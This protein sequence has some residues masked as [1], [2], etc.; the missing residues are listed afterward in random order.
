MMN[1]ISLTRR[2]TQKN[3]PTL[4]QAAV[5][6]AIELLWISWKNKSFVNSRDTLI[7]LHACWCNALLS[8]ICFTKAITILERGVTH[9]SNKI[10]DVLAQ[11]S[12]KILD[13]LAQV[14]NRVVNCPELAET[15]QYHIPLEP[16][17]KELVIFG[18]SQLTQLVRDAAE[19]FNVDIVSI[20]RLYDQP[21]FIVSC[22]RDTPG[23]H[24]QTLTKEM[25]PHS[26]I[27]VQYHIEPV[28]KE[29]L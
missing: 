2:F 18:E 17:W 13:V 29:Y 20:I 26:F 10:W 27:Q 16:K 12:N 4:I 8:D 6:N 1:I 11:K 21:L 3:P 25:S 22:K 7:F 9:K 15:L 23:E 19:K 14:F 5:L 28:M 24:L